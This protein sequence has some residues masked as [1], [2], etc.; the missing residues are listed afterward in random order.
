MNGVAQSAFMEASQ[1]VFK[2]ECSVYL[3]DASGT[4]I[5]SSPPVAGFSLGSLGNLKVTVAGKTL[6]LCD[7]DDAALLQASTSEE[8]LNW[9]RFLT[10]SPLSNKLVVRETPA[11]PLT[12]RP[13]SSSSAASSSSA[14]K[15]PA[16]HRRL[17]VVPSGAGTEEQKGDE[18]QG[19]EAAVGEAAAA[20]SKS[21]AKPPAQAQGKGKGRAAAG[22]EAD[23]D[24][25]SS[26]S[27][28]AAA[29]AAAA[30][31]L[32]AATNR[33]AQIEGRI[34]KV[35]EEYCRALW[36][37]E[38]TVVTECR[39][40]RSRERKRVK[41]GYESLS[42]RLQTKVMLPSERTEEE[43]KLN[44][45][46]AE[47]LSVIN[48][49]AARREERAEA[50]YERFRD[51]QYATLV[52]RQ[53]KLQSA[54]QQASRQL[55]ALCTS[56]PA[57]AEA[58]AKAASLD[59]ARR[60]E[61]HEYR[62][63]LLGQDLDPKD[64]KLVLAQAKASG[65]EEEDLAKI[66]PPA[67]MGGRLASTLLSPQG[68]AGEPRDGDKIVI[69][70]QGIEPETRV[71]LI[72]AGGA[73]VL[74]RPVERAHPEGSW[75]RL[76]RSRANLQRDLD[77]LAARGLGRERLSVEQQ[78][79][80][81]RVRLM[82]AAT[83]RKWRAGASSSSSSFPH[84]AHEYLAD[85]L[86]LHP[87]RVDTAA[88][89]SIIQGGWRCAVRRRAMEDRF[90]KE[91]E[92]ARREVEVVTRVQAVVRGRRGRR[93]AAWVMRR[94]L[95]LAEKKAMKIIKE[96][97]RVWVHRWRLRKT[98]HARLVSQCLGRGLQRRD[99]LAAARRRQR[100]EQDQSY[101]VV[102]PSAVSSNRP[103]RAGR[104][105]VGAHVTHSAPAGITEALAM[106]AL[107][108][109]DERMRHGRIFSAL[110]AKLLPQGLPQG[111]QGAGGARALGGAGAGAGAG[112]L[113]RL[114]A[115]TLQAGAE[116]VE[117]AAGTNR[118]QPKPPAPQAQARSVEA[119]K[120]EAMRRQAVRAFVQLK[121]REREQLRRVGGRQAGDDGMQEEG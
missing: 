21:N 53:G 12:M 84:E 10:T 15:P 76:F 95:A 55:A 60:F 111:L 88:S 62:R 45:W 85:H 109:V 34:R 24:S 29:A 89:A 74:D 52:K 58:A 16:A 19:E 36:E 101:N 73:L 46:L 105:L 23:E 47:Q 20:K 25:S 63:A 119:M 69:G 1:T 71:L 6:S 64:I 2:G 86:H 81:M 61:R 4:P 67:V 50:D 107:S 93:F 70:G 42:D 59:D 57:G 40:Y 117:A 31:A 11:T 3:C 112:G 66:A 110:T 83:K 13:P 98:T 99:E 5:I 49:M 94:R 90:Q 100:V 121:E 38:K 32:A 27:S 7:G 103:G 33:V 54:L 120:G 118:S 75:V 106:H 14:R 113:G 9:G 26:S 72:V 17:L 114:L 104:G 18:E 30:A 78:A 97:L 102:A 8:A 116:A 51:A 43:A 96:H 87:D 35:A 115:G 92:K 65:A 48:K 68:P 41:A 91:A 22:T 37:R 80:L 108:R 39:Q 56:G 77:E 82:I 28:S 79:V 44:A